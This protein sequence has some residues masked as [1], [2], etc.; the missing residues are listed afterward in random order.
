VQERLKYFEE[1]PDLTDFF[2]RDLPLNNQLINQ[3]SSLNSYGP[4]ALADWLKR[5]RAQLL[6]QNDW[7]STA[8]QITLNQLLE[9]T[10]QKPRVLFSLIR[11][12]V[13]QSPSS[14]GLAETMETLG[15]DV[16]LR[17]IDAQIESFP[18]LP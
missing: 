5:A 6:A 15:K 13:T 11:I 4:S 16:A 10:G 9:E 18:D 7:S 12:A 14:P 17:R 8:L 2:F 3:N 1:L